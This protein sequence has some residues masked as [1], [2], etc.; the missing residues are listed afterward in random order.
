MLVALA[1]SEP[2][3]QVPV[4]GSVCKSVWAL[5]LAILPH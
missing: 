3:A 4:T 1:G 2:K 5:D